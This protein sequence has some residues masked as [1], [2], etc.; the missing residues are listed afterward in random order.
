M[1]QQQLRQQLDQ[2]SNAIDGLQAAAEDKAKL[3]ELIVAI[4]RQLAEP[5]LKPNLKGETRNLVEQVDGM[6]ASFESEHPTIAA[7]LN[8]IIV[9]LTS[10]GV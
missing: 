3:S 7:I 5:L 2:L 1:D 4:E 6:V 10:M 9:T 8:N